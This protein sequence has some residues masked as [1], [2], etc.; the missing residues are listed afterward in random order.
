MNKFITN[1]LLP[2][3]RA[4]YENNNISHHATAKKKKKKSYNDYT[5]KC[6]KY[7]C[8]NASNF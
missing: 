8:S 1:F 4:R 2:D 6:S 7:L 3:I 5:A